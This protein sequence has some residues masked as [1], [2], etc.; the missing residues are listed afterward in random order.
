MKKC[1]HIFF[2]SKSHKSSNNVT[3]NL[4][5]PA[6]M[7]SLVQHGLILSDYIHLIRDNERTWICPDPCESRTIFL[8]K[9]SVVISKDGLYYIHAQATFKGPIPSLK[10]SVILFINNT[11]LTVKRLLSEATLFGPGTISLSRLYRLKSGDNIL[12]EIN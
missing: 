2:Q 10:T 5:S 12:L 3:E 7:R 1:F 6:E 11:T 4:P 9:G 8:K